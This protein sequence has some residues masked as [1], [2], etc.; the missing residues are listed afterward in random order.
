MV[1]LGINT[2]LR[3]P[4]RSIIADLTDTDRKP[5]EKPL[6]ELEQ[7]VLAAA[8]LDALIK[9][10]TGAHP[11]AKRIADLMDH[12]VS[13]DQLTTF[14]ENLQ[15][16]RARPEAIKLYQGIIQSIKSDLVT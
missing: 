6:C 2:R 15:R 11:A 10:G 1:E 5:A 9:E 14:R 13:A 12:E 8:S 3:A 4:V 16:G 7:L